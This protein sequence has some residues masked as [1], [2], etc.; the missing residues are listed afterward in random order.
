M[1]SGLPM[2]GLQRR[3]GWQPQIV[4][5]MDVT[6]EQLDVPAGLRDRRILERLIDL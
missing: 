2:A 6:I 1:L 3:C 4:R 5:T